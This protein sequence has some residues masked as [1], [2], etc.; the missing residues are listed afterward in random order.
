VI[1]RPQM[2]ASEDLSQPRATAGSD[3]PTKIDGRTILSA[4][5]SARRTHKRTPKPLLK[6]SPITPRYREEIQAP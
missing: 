5:T 6:I 4:I 2:G 1:G 3:D